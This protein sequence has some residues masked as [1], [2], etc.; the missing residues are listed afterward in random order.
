MEERDEVLISPKMIFEV[1]RKNLVFIIITVMVFSLGTFF[2]TNFLITKHY[3]ST[4]S[5]YVETVDLQPDS[6]NSAVYSLNMQNYALKLVNTYIRMLDTNT[7]YTKLSD[8][9][10]EKRRAEQD[11]FLQK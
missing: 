3:T 1:L 11:D 8:E 7:F 9:L 10:D 6:P 2:I 5:L 4:I